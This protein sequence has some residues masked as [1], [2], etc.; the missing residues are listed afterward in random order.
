MTRCLNVLML[1]LF[2][3]AGAL[4][5]DNFVTN[6]Y[7]PYPPG[8]AGDPGRS[9]VPFAQGRMVTLFDPQQKRL[10]DVQLDAWRSTCSEPGRSVIWLRFTAKRPTTQLLLLEVPPISARM[11]EQAYEQRLVT[12]PNGWGMEGDASR[13]QSYL[14]YHGGEVNH[15]EEKSWTFLLDGP[16]QD[17]AGMVNLYDSQGLSAEQ[18]NQSFKL[19]LG[20]SHYGIVNEIE[21]PATNALIHTDHVMPLNGRL[22]GL[23]ALGGAADQG[24]TIT[25]ADRIAPTDS[26]ATPRG[27]GPLVLILQQYTF[28]TSGELLWLSGSAD[29]EQGAREVTLS[30]VRVEGGAFLGAT[31]AQRT[32]AGSVRIVARG[33]ND[34]VYEYDFTPLGLGSGER[35]MQRLFSLETAGYD[36]RDYAAKVA[37]NQ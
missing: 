22:S 26:P 9:D 19:I 13:D 34:L 20:S 23:W 15:P 4:A 36:C 11:G 32:H 35:I 21:V 1:G 33:C 37:G 24:V 14:V 8:C 7:L 17:G 18:Y 25:I 6:P 28:D 16:V 3:C 30:I 29:F 12:S 2:C 27:K 10:V 5:H 31:V